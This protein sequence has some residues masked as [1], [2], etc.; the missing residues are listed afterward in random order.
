MM[1]CRACKK[2]HSPLLRCGQAAAIARAQAKYAPEVVSAVRARFEA[3]G[4]L[5]LVADTEAATAAQ[6]RAALVSLPPGTVAY[7]RPVSRRRHGKYLE[8][9]ERL[10]MMR[11]YTHL[12]RLMVADGAL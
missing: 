7:G 6:A 9:D 1:K 8:P 5:K 2:E 4:A 10:N 3:A 12:K 11:M